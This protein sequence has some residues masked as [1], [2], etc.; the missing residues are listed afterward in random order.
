MIASL[1][2]ALFGSYSKDFFRQKFYWGVY[3]FYQRSVFCYYFSRAGHFSGEFQLSIY[4][5]IQSFRKIDFLRM[6]ITNQEFNPLRQKIT[7]K[8]RLIPILMHYLWLI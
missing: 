8:N 5:R 1:K 2:Q 6:S 7:N 4:C 3:S